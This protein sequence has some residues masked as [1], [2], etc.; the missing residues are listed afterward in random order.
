MVT[1]KTRRVN[2][3][4]GVHADT[5]FSVQTEDADY[6]GQKGRRRVNQ[7]RGVHAADTFLVFASV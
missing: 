4:R 6:F 5:F 2:E 7:D 3:D 1:L